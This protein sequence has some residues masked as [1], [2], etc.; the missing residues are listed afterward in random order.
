[1]RIFAGISMMNARV[2]FCAHAVSDFSL[3][4]E[5]MRTIA[6]L[7]AY[8][9]ASSTRKMAAIFLQLLRSLF[10]DF[11]R[12]IPPRHLVHPLRLPVS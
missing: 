4:A 6:F 11:L 12:P 9:L 7:N 1:M 8:L 5:A 3:Q 10:P 2:R